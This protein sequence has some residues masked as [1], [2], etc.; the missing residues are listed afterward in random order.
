M[1]ER[2]Q[3]EWTEGLIKV[4]DDPNLGWSKNAWAL[5]MPIY[6]K[7]TIAEDLDFIFVLISSKIL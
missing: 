4:E 1:Q 6:K 3:K 2:V 7:E 5:S